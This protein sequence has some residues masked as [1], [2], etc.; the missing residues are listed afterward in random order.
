[1]NIYCETW[2]QR[3]DPIKKN[4]KTSIISLYGG[5]LLFKKMMLV[6]TIN[7]SNVTIN[8]EGSEICAV[9][10]TESTASF[11]FSFLNYNSG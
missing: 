10:K 4:K 6:K 5:Y 9:F 7:N 11:C 3:E 2:L 1:M 8:G